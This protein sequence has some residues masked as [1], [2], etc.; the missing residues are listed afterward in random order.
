MRLKN[1]KVGARVVVDSITVEIN[2]KVRWKTLKKIGG[3]IVK[4][5][6]EYEH[7]YHT[8]SGGHTHVTKHLIHND[9]YPTYAI[10]L[11]NNVVDIEGNNVIVVR[12]HDLKFLDYLPDS[13]KQVTYSEY[14]KALGI[15]KKYEYQK[16]LR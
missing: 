1:K 6:P 14:R 13:Y 5:K 12:E 7:Y 16:S 3:R 4:M 9:C 2:P 11:D 15:I 10:K 8:C